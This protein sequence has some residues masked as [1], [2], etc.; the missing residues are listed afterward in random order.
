[1]T[2][3]SQ[4]VFAV[5]SADRGWLESTDISPNT[6]PGPIRFRIALR[7]SGEEMLNFTV[8]EITTIRLLPGSPLEKIVVPRFNTVSLAYRQGCAKASAVRSAKYGCLR[9]TDNLPLVTGRASAV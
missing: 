7:P 3:S 2:N 9:S 1:M 6:S 8:P 5:P 4:L